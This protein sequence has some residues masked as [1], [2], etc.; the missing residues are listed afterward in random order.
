MTTDALLD[1][2]ANTPMHK[3]HYCTVTGKILPIG[4]DGLTDPEREQFD[5]IKEQWGHSNKDKTSI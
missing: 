5:K 2:I 4:D 3:R 1:I